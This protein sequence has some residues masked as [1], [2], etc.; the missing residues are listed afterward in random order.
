MRSRDEMI[1]ANLRFV[2]DVAKNVKTVDSSDLIS[3]GNL[4]LITAADRF[5]GTK[6]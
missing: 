6:G 1:R 4:G 3:A 5:D 2:V